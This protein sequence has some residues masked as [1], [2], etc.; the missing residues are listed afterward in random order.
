[1]SENKTLNDE[2]NIDKVNDEPVEEASVEE[3]EAEIAKLNA[4]IERKT[5]KVKILNDAIKDEP[6]KEEIPEIINP[7]LDTDRMDRLDLKMDGYPDEIVE[8]IMKL[9]GKS[10][11]QSPITKRVVDEM[12]QEYRAE[13]AA[14]IDISNKSDWEKKYSHKDLENKSAEELEKILP[15]TDD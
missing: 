2:K 8:E 11:L 7:S 3:K 15:H 12:H 1:M 14:N 10:A 5:K 4:I 6:E 9:G 13:T